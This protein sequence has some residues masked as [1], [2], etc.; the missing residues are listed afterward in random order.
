MSGSG[1]LRAV[2]H[3]G[4]AAG[5]GALAWFDGDQPGPADD[6][7]VIGYLLAPGRAEWFRCAAGVANG[8]DG[9]R[10]LGDA[11]EL[12][13]TCGTRQLRWF[14]QADGY[15][16]AVCLGEDAAVMPPG[17]PVGAAD[18]PQRRRLADTE[19]RILAGRV[20]RARDGWATLATARYP[21]CDVPVA[22][23]VGQE[24]WAFLAEYAVR[25][26]HG[27]VSVA[28]TLLLSLTGRD[29]ALAGKERRE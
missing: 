19:E 16:Q 28:D 10:D 27:N 13:A 1:V 4:P 22:A 9:P 23:S 25:D 6:G 26:G 11:Y 17:E 29:L 3:P 20:I 12:F 24:V 15:G 18:A 5:S 2:H 21:S 7:D 8:P 14:H